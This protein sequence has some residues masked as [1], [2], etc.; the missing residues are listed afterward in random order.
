MRLQS[1]GM[2]ETEMFDVRRN[3][4]MRIVWYTI[5]AIVTA[6][7]LVWILRS[8]DEPPP[9]QA[10]ALSK[11]TMAASSSQHPI[12][13]RLD[14][15]LPELMREHRVPGV[16]IAL[17]R[18]GEIE[19]QRGYGTAETGKDIAITPQT[20]FNV[21]SVSKSLS[22]WG[23][24]KMV[25]DGRIG[26]HEPAFDYI[27]RWRLPA[28][29]HDEDGVTIAR[30]LSHTSGVYG[31]GVSDWGPDDPLPPI[32]RS[33]SGLA[34]ARPTVLRWQPG[35][36][37]Q[38]S[39]GGYGLLQLLII[40]VT[41]G[42]FETYMQ[43][44]I[45]EP[46]GLRR[47]RYIRED[48]ERIQPVTTPH[49]PFDEPTYMRRR[50]IT[51]GGGLSSTIEDLANFALALCDLGPDAPPGRSVLQPETIRAMLTPAPAANGRWGLGYCIA[52]LSPE[53]RLVGHTGGTTGWISDYWIDPERANGFVLL[54]NST[55][56]VDLHVRILTLYRN[57][58]AATLHPDTTVVAV[59]PAISKLLGQWK[60]EIDTGERTISFT[61]LLRANESG[62][63][64]GIY[65][66]WNGKRSAL[67]VLSLTPDDFRVSITRI[68][69]SYFH[70]LS[71]APTRIEGDYYEDA[72]MKFSMTKL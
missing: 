27:T 25:E 6:L 60:G 58:Y 3:R 7:T 28:S 42:P 1:V 5:A 66:F 33:L 19:W 63:V 10:V 46:L 39:N 15:L 52:P 22:T 41:G 65:T 69:A 34:G 9:S 35:T 70:A 50:S 38:Y 13:R 36:R 17:I 21:G 48:Y 24:M 71:V 45:I 40:E 30:L 18:D 14:T 29:G 23:I 37:F 56:A 12:A 4:G 53:A 54:S 31:D 2:Y 59:N 55:N 32:E 16:G 51:V 68:G 67:K 26:L 62:A 64:E 61:M 8:W 20:S 47:S 44:T 11:D 57:W 43:K 49:H 72:K